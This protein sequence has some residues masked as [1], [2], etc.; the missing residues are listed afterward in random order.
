MTDINR[1]PDAPQQPTQGNPHLLAVLAHAFVFTGFLLPLIFW[2]IGKDQSSF[3]DAEGKKALNFGILVTLG[4]VAASVVGAV[5]FIGWVSG[6]VSAAVF[7]IAV[8][9]GVQG[10]VAANRGA[11][12]RYPFT[13]DLIK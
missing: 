11:A 8:I 4:Y 12:Y 13:I 10:A 5:P 1:A 7:V 2:L 6:L 3:A 9:F